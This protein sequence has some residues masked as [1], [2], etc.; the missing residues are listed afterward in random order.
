MTNEHRIQQL[1]KGNHAA[2]TR[3][4]FL[5]RAAGLSALT[6]PALTLFTSK[7]RAEDDAEIARDF[8]D[9]RR[10]ENDH[11]AFLVKALGD[12]ARPKPN[13][14]NL[15]QAT[16]PD[17]AAVTRAL[18]NTGV[19]AYLGALPVINRRAYIAAA[20]SIAQIEAR[21]A[22]WI[23]TF[24]GD[25]ITTNLFGDEQSFER[26]FTIDEVVDSASPFIADL[27]GGPPLTFDP[28]PSDDNDIAILNFALALEYLEAEFYNINVPRFFGK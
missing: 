23:N 27:N 2:P 15:E 6:L 12:S 8:Q 25:H 7:A 21:H 5:T 28:T 10:H 14:Q 20:G 11:V 22:G 13:F 9:I 3:R 18:E 4:S 26:A 1:A 24:S 17:L 16:L 19:G